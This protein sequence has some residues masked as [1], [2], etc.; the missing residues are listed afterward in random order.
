MAERG[1][2]LRSGDR[3]DEAGGCIV[4]RSAGAQQGELRAHDE[5][6]GPSV[7]RHLCLSGLMAGDRCGS[8]RL[9]G[10]RIAA[11]APRPLKTGALVAV[12]AAGGAA[13][14]EA[15]SGLTLTRR[16]EACAVGAAPRRDWGGGQ[17]MSVDLRPHR[18]GGAA[19]TENW[20][21]CRGWRG[22]GR[23]TH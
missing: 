13:L 16:I 14:T 2:R 19:P 15:G 6:G 11:G 5:V 22:R 3:S 23:S 17:A 4:R 8:R 9:N 21:A 20:R 1:V 18:G 10:G 7:R 12:R